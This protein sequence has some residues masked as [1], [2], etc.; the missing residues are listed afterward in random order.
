MSN[1]QE[2]WKKIQAQLMQRGQQSAAQSGQK[3]KASGMA[4]A[5]VNGATTAAATIGRNLIS[6]PQPRNDFERWQQSYAMSQQ[7]TIPN[8]AP[9]RRV[10]GAAQSG[11]YGALLGNAVQQ[12]KSAGAYD[13]EIAPTT[14][15]DKEKQERI[16]YLKNYIAELE[17]QKATWMDT[18][19]GQS[20]L[21]NYQ[22]RGGDEMHSKAF[23]DA[24][25]GDQDKFI[26]TINAEYDRMIT[27][28][29]KE[30]EE[31]D[32]KVKEAQWDFFQTPKAFKNGY[33]FG[34]ITKTI[35]GTTADVGMGLVKGAAQ[36]VEGVLDL[37]VHAVGWGA[38]ALGFDETA[39][40][41][42]QQAS[43]NQVAGSFASPDKF[44]DG[45]SALGKTMDAVTEGVGQVGVNIA[46]GG[47]GKAAGW[48][49][50]A[51]ALLTYG[52][53]GAS[54]M[55]SGM[56]EA[57][58][59]P[60]GA[61]DGE[62]FM[63]GLIA[64]A[65][66][67]ATEMLFGGIGKGVNMLGFNKG[68]SSADDMIAKKVASVFNNQLTKNLV[69]FGIKSSAE[70]LEE[71]LAGGLQALGKKMTYM[72]E[73]DWSDILADE[74]LFEQFIVGALTSGISQG[75]GLNRA[76][77]TGT[78]F[79]TGFNQNEQAVIQREV[80]N[81]IAEEQKDGKKLTARQIAEIKARVEQDIEKGYIS[82]DTI[83]EVLG[84]DGYKTYKDTSAKLE[85]LQSEYDALYQM[86]HS[87]KSDAQI[88]RQAELK[89]QIDGIKAT[90]N[91]KQ[92]QAQI[93]N[94]VYGLV[95]GG[96]L[97]ESYYEG[98]RRKQAYQADLSKYDKKQQAIVKAAVD[99]GVLNNTNRTHDF[100]DMIAK[101]SAE[102]G[103]SFS[104]T[105]N[106]KLKESGFALNGKTINGYVTKD[107]ITLNV[108]S[109]KSLNKVVGHE[110][111]HVLEGTEFYN[112]VRQA[113]Y[114]Y[115]QTKG[116]WK[117]RYDSIKALYKDV[118]D[119]DIKAE[120]T[121]DLIGDYLF[122]DPD[123][124]KNLSVNHRNVFQKMYDEIKYLC[125]V[126]TAG[127]KELRQLE[128]AK[129]AF[130]EAYRS[131]GKAQKNTA[132]GGV[133][134]SINE[135]F[136]DQ[137]NKWDGKTTGF[138]FVVG[139][140]SLALQDAG[141]PQKQIRW[142]ASKIKALLDKHDGMT[143]DTVKQIPGL[144]EN[145][146]IVVDS[147]KGNNSKI[148]MGD[149]YDENGK[150]VTAVLLLTPSSRKGNVLDFFKVSSAEGR[151]HI[152]SLFTNEDGTSVPIRYVD[153]KRI[154][155]WLNANRLQL[156]LHNLDLD[157]YSII[158]E[159]EGNVKQQYSLSD[160]DGNQLTKE[161][162]EYFKDSKIRDEKGNLM[163]MY[164]GS[165]ETFT[166][167]NKK[168]AKSSGYYGNGFYFTD[169]DSHAG[170]YGHKYQV[171][172]N[173]TNPLQDGTND[174][175]KE[176]LRKFI[177]AVADN[178]D[179]GID[180]Y[181]YGA[182][183]D[184][185]T[186]SVYGKSDFAMLMD[187]NASCVGNMVETIELFNEVNSTD[188]NGIIAPTETV[189]FYPHQI[190]SVANTKP[191]GDPDIRK[192]L[193]NVGETQK[194]TGKYNVYGKDIAL[195]SALED[196]SPLPQNVTIVKDAP[197]TISEPE[198]VAE[199]MFPDALPTVEQEIDSLSMQ[200]DDLVAQITEKA[201]AG[202][203]DSEFERICR[204]C[205]ALQNQK[206]ALEQEVRSDA[207]DRL[208]SLDDTDVPPDI[209]PV[210][211]EQ[212]EV[213]PITKK[214]ED[215]I[216][217]NVRNSLALDN[218]DMADVHRIIRGY[219]NGEIIGR[220]Q[221]FGELKKYNSYA[222]SEHR[223]DVA[224]A[225]AWLRDQPV[226]VDDTIKWGLADYNILRRQN[227]GK[228]RF[229]NDGAGVDVVYRELSEMWP[230]LFPESIYV[231]GDQFEQMIKVANMD[232][233]HVVDMEIPDKAIMD[234]VDGIIREVGKYRQ[235]QKEKAANKYGR[236][237]FESLMADAD[238]HIP[239]FSQEA[240]RR[241]R[242]RPN[243]IKAGIDAPAFEID[244]DARS[245]TEEQQA[246]MP[247][248]DAKEA[249]AD[250]PVTR[251][252]LQQGIID[253]MKDEFHVR[254]YE[255]DDVLKNAKN[256][257]TFKTVDNTP[258]RVMEK[259]LGYREGQILSDLTVNMVAQNETE[260]I[261]WLNSFTDRK[262]GLLAQ[263][264]QRYHI[265]PG[266]KE[267]AAAQMYAEG[268]YVDDKD[269]I[270][271]YGDKELAVD[272]PNAVTRARIKSLARDP[273]IRK[274]YDETLAAINESR[275][276]NGYP[277]IPRLDNYFLHFR[278]QTDTFS[279]IGLPFNPNDIRAKDL[280][281][282]LNGVTADLKPGQPFFASAMHRKGKRTSFDLLGGLEQ[283]LTSA[284]NQIYHI[285]DIQKLRALRNYIAD[286]YG[287]ANG[288]EG[289]SELSEEEQQERIEKVYDAHL[290]T[291]AKFLNEE[292]NVLAGKTALID[293]GLEG[294][295]GR[296][297]ITF[298]D[299]VNRQVGSNMVG[300][301]ASSAI[302][303][304]DA[305]PRALAKTNKADF[306]KAFGQLVGSKVGSIFGRN[307]G[308]TENSP[309][310][311]RRKGADRFYRTPFQKVADVGYVAMG[312]VDNVATELIA[313]TKY[314]E[315]VRKGM[316]SQ[317][318]HFET[319]KW[320]SKLM[321]DRSLGQMPQ[322]YNSK[323]L[324]LFTKFQLEVRNNLDSQ[325]YDTIQEKK[326]SNEE[327][328]N[329]LWRN[330]KTAAKVTSTFF[331]LA[332]AQHLFGKAF[333]SVAGY[334][335]S[336]DIIEVLMKAFGF[337]DD[338]ESEDTVLDNIEQGFMALLEDMPYTSTFTGGRIPISSA[339][340]IEELVTGK[341]QYG[342]EK[343][344]WETLGEIAPYYV[345]PGGYGQAKKTHQGLSMFSD[346]H[347]IAGSY[348][349][350][351]DL[352]F[353][354][355]DTT[356]NRI[357]A[358]LFG[359]YASDNAGDYFDQGRKPLN[360]KQIQEFIDVDLPI[361]A[362]WDYRDGLKGL[363]NVSEQA[364]YINSL[365]I[366][367]WKKNLLINN[368]TD[369]K[370]PIDMTDYGMYG[371]FEEFDFAQKNPEKYSFFRNNG[372]SYS[373]YA[374]ADEDVKRTYTWAY[375]NPEKF[376]LSQAVTSDLLAYRKY[377][378]DLS[379]IRADYDRNG[380][381]ISGTAKAKKKDYIFSLP[382][383]DDGQ[384]AIL[385]RSLYD[386]A[387]DKA[388]YNWYIV[389]YL[390]NREDITYTEMLTILKELGFTIG[391]DGVTVSW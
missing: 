40:F 46:T 226:K 43:M 240:Y 308:F 94:Q 257:S 183:V 267:S 128:K 335:P 264:S 311:I 149:V 130:A 206:E 17:N 180:N 35:L 64:G 136:Y 296:R 58:S 21:A 375:E 339:L 288:L 132:D 261:K 233:T 383:L 174:I 182:T 97:A 106:Q 243:A 197:G 200:I 124:I 133:Q 295:I 90:F 179:Y 18:P 207:A 74:N 365:D 186:D 247:D 334:N 307:D 87:E 330:A 374:A 359:Q 109:A 201:E 315:F 225:K 390:N 188:Y 370:E 49:S 361:Q 325:F 193:S 108:N 223:E 256:L 258:Q 171:Y 222:E 203:Y 192:S 224:E 37:G 205:E 291:F 229:S 250:K 373:D 281:T 10:L 263:L 88:D 245:K 319:D 178:E 304:L 221:L 309:V 289:L 75:G 127:S 231:P 77:K 249:V 36:T 102:K 67:I 4:T 135:K 146:V 161:Q 241:L 381:A 275:K 73:K 190:K 283:Y 60:N 235:T 385:Y 143:I 360:E 366:P 299:T 141:L 322:L 157:S 340:P 48:G 93:R 202:Q 236:E 254:G 138:S 120:L 105:N 252:E 23:H 327:I 57:Y 280:P 16:K 368:L 303:N 348:T 33:D 204:E 191:T 134:Y 89:K 61:T 195:P 150:I 356:W 7:P 52:I 173:I 71:V 363:S 86:K 269:N 159:V 68:L 234:V 181:G 28:A 137:V 168:K 282:D 148:V 172:L 3:T 184:S 72:S 251:K 212:T 8:T 95:K 122:T 391:A 175:T 354:V 364:D 211:D 96:R 79:I 386:S 272:F 56:S 358:G 177:E 82:T 154:Q 265:K 19:E 160:S 38:D 103:V 142:D 101:V 215:D 123:F 84:G 350:K 45:Y 164:H 50:K 277:E 314:N 14:G 380:K 255:L 305:I 214:L 337:D 114:D 44:L 219:V 78:D 54:S 131:N 31:L 262:D 152:K 343:S 232:S 279:R 111:A 379:D 65:A 285:D 369:R 144:L 217:R 55:G 6:A 92:A 189:A 318:A 389:D 119:A 238:K 125:S 384:K 220:N 39:D 237:S 32:P 116:E 99:S 298:L 253:D 286:T 153:K 69:E 246:F 239:Q 216:A 213:I 218:K 347:P 53:M 324:G 2:E 341:D 344:R 117:Q 107:G 378:D 118:A 30:L 260:G 140:T 42:H 336:F 166:V 332:V 357:Q 317:Q 70:G 176:Q 292:A 276:R 34:D 271:Q 320:V 242:E 165:P 163:V 353:P 274:I 11:V 129:K 198:T 278:A 81:R 155:S 121:A 199:G 167:F 1:Y 185:I 156:P 338:E 15:Q 259:A 290:S 310:I 376:T 62:A 227:F 145:P 266:S 169:S 349:D 302:V 371:S 100:V 342:N 9:D 331:Q 297:G 273:R 328:Q 126:A 66:D 326:A 113:I 209:G 41:L 47:I 26:D 210:F 139:E 59:N 352:R 316:D 372:I 187:I 147:K 284:K 112:E 228:I 362:Y 51:S 158:G 294:I 244:T 248:V 355:E 170:Q 208:S 115:A 29:R 333:E 345:L 76:N 12:Q 270:V 306:V 98:A 110:I 388:Q 151:S 287:Q 329:G 230:Q 162:T 5:G 13:T 104:F 63:Y 382:G 387:A 25:K 91:G 85:S 323:M 300:F 20:Q 22:A 312:A 367:V 196:I 27:Q 293:R 83:E 346:D 351:G 80:E 194:S 24:V 321:G 301:S 377:T 313:R 268:F